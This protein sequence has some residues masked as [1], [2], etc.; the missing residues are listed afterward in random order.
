SQ[1]WEARGIQSAYGHFERL[2]GGPEHAYELVGRRI[3]ITLGEGDW[4][5]V[6]A[7][8]CNEFEVCSSEWTKEI[9]ETRLIGINSRLTCYR[10]QSLVLRPSGQLHELEA[11]QLN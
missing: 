10:E 1:I 8:R 3:R 11:V 5:D 7:R 4:L 6:V 9:C 2:D